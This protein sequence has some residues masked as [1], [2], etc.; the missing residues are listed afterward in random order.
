MRKRDYFYFIYDFLIL[1]WS[2]GD[3][4]MT[5]NKLNL[6]NEDP[7]HGISK[8]IINKAFKFL[9]LIVILINQK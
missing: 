6:G 9:T 4:P 8:T 5:R 3:S 7:H 1:F 2:R